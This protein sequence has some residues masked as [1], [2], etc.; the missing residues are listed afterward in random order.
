[1]KASDRRFFKNYF[2]KLKEEKNINTIV[3]SKQTIKKVKIS[4]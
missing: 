3:G 2:K 1:M 4:S